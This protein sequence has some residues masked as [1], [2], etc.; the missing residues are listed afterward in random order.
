MMRPFHLSKPKQIT[1]DGTDYFLISIRL[2]GEK[3]MGGVTLADELD[4][5]HEIELPDEVFTEKM[6]SHKGKSGAE[7]VRAFLKD[8]FQNTEVGG[9]AGSD[10]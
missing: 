10:S 7:G 6:F 4:L 2:D 8:S 5:L 1:V 9:T 3:I